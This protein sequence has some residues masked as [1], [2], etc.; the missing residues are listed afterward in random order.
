MRW[1]RASEFPH[2]DLASD[3]SLPQKRGSSSRAVSGRRFCRLGQR[4]PPA[5]LG[6]PDGL[7][8]ADISRL[9]PPR[10]PLQELG[11]AWRGRIHDLNVFRENPFLR[12]VLV[13]RAERI[14]SV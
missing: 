7:Q 6:L 10:P 3:S 9:S 11:R 5:A 8:D 4:P 2:S 13:G 14:E 12:L 1:R